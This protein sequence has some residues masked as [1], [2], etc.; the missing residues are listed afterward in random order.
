MFT[1]LKMGTTARRAVRRDEY[2]TRYRA[3]K[4]TACTTRHSWPLVNILTFS[5]SLQ[6]LLPLIGGS[7]C[8]PKVF[9]VKF[10]KIYITPWTH[11]WC[12]YP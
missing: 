2:R 8:I 4:S 7:T 12:P 6:S 3:N 11:V 10:K 5:H 1:Q 9:V